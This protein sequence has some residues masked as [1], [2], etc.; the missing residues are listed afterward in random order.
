MC[1]V[2]RLL[3]VLD[4]TVVSSVEDRVSTGFRRVVQNGELATNAQFHWD[5][6]ESII[7]MPGGKIP[8]DHNQ[9]SHPLFMSIL[10][11][12]CPSNISSWLVGFNFRGIVCMFFQGCTCV[13]PFRA[14][15]FS[16]LANCACLGM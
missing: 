2:V 10:Q 7:L 8:L 13:W 16:T 1:A 5:G 15:L 4:C 9:V 11:E 14:L 12:S 6:T 3:G